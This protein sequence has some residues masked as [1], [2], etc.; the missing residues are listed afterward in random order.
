MQTT[1]NKTFTLEQMLSITTG[2]LCCGMDDVYQILN[3]ITG[4]NLFTHA[5][6]RAAKFAAPLL[7]ADHPELT[8]ANACL[9]KLDGWVKV[10]RTERKTECVKMWITELRMMF[11]EIGKTFEV[12]SYA[13]AW[14]SIDPIAELESMVGKGKIAVIQA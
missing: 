6:P 11:P 8:P 7:L 3:H 5:L 10:D 14:L 13:D 1:A 9:G 12:R 2:R 4:D